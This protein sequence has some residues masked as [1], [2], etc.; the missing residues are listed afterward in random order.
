MIEQAGPDPDAV[1]VRRVLAG[2][3]EAFAG[4]VHRWQGPLV[5]LAYRYCRNRGQAEEMAQEAFLKAYRFLSRWQEDAPFKSW[6][7]TVAANVY[8]SQMRRNRPPEVS[9]DQLR[10]FAGGSNPGDALEVDDANE[11]VRRA[12]TRL[13]GKYRDAVVLFYFHEM[14]IARAALTL[15]L[16]EGTLKARL[17]R[18]RALLQR[19]LSTILSSP[20]RAEAT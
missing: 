9:L 11:A 1:D 15:G 17:H 19:K 12:V 13:P 10:K 4:V 8:R 18:G 3:V 14:D 7:F 2:D 5:T 6:L 16:P 20:R